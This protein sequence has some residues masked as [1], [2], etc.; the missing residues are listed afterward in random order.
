MTKE[1]HKEYACKCHKLAENSNVICDLCKDYHKVPE[2]EEEARQII[3]KVCCDGQY[4]NESIDFIKSTL[5]KEKEKWI[6]K[7]KNAYA[8]LQP[9]EDPLRIEDII[10]L[11][12]DK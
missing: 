4:V 6:E 10:T 2:W 9:W 5:E 11:L 3:S 12:E 7:I 1:P 8:E